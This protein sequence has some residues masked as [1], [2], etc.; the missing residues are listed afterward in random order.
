MENKM[1]SLLAFALAMTI[2]LN[3]PPTNGDISCQEAL[4]D[5]IPC[6]PYLE[7][8]GPPTPTVRCCIGVRNVNA[9]ATTTEI[10]RGLCECFK[11]A[12]ASM[13]IDPQKLMKLPEFCQVSVPVTLD[14][15]VD[16]SKI[17]LF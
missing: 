14:P 13:P 9:N 17:S 4:C 10:R 7:S 15:K 1:A 11:K 16:C 2:V 8:S 12:A 3:A 5:L 6:Q